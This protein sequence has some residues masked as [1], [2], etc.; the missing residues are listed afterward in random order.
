M[1]ISR[2]PFIAGGIA[3]LTAPSIVA[4]QSAGKMLRIGVLGL[5]A[6]SSQEPIWDAFVAEMARR[7]HVVG[8]NLAIERPFAGKDAQAKIGP[9]LERSQAILTSTSKILEDNRPRLAE[10]TA[11]M[12][13]IAKTAREQSSGPSIFT[14]M[15][16]HH[17]LMS[18]S[19]NG[20]NGLT[21]PAL[22]TSTS[23]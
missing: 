4:P 5:G 1:K 16:C 6:S 21:V 3:L 10:I 18:D 11:E 12:L 2:R 20:P 8:R 17:S 14:S 15:P 19:H 13:A 9:L 22:L 7:G 23:S